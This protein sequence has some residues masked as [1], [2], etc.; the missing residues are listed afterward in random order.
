[1]T[2]TRTPGRMINVTPAQALRMARHT[3]APETGELL[4]SV[5][6]NATQGMVIEIGPLAGLALLHIMT[7]AK[8]AGV[9]L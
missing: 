8:R 1:L 9:E 5:A 3:I 4:R 2:P 6:V 7:A